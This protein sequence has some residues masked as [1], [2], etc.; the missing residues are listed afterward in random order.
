MIRFCGSPGVSL[1]ATPLLTKV[2]TRVIISNGVTVLVNSWP[3]ISWLWVVGSWFVISR[4]MVWSGFVY[5]W[6]MI[7]SWSWVINW[8]NFVDWSRVID[9][10][11]FIG[12]CWV[13]WCWVVWCRVS[14]SW[15][16]NWN[17][18]W[19]MNSSAVFFNSIW[20]VYILRGSMGLAGNDGMVTTM[21]LMDR[22][23]YSR[24]ISMFNDLMAALVG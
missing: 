18:S 14:I 21:R 4:G 23:T 1:V 7:W 11:W 17:V 15:G 9:W 24:S 10:G 6:G 22:M 16:M 2:N 20:I 13:V 3:I 19:S 8:S 5:N 12:W